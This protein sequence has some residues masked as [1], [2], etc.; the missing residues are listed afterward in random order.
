MIS[1]PAEPPGSRVTTVY[2]PAA[3][4]RSA[5]SL[6]WVDLP[7]PSPPS[8]V[9]K[10]PRVAADVV[11]NRYSLQLQLANA[12]PEPADHEF[13]CGIE[14]TPRHGTLPNRLGRVHGNFNRHI[15]SAP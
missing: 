1:A 10:R 8:K 5:N 15:G 2:T 11:A 3:R 14:R 6:T 7:V 12:G 13:A 9:M 4:S